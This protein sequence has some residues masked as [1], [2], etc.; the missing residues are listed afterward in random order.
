[1]P[2][3]VLLGTTR[4]KKDGGLFSFKA[5]TCLAEVGPL[6]T[7]IKNPDMCVAGFSALERTG[8]V[9]VTVSNT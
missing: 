8:L 7:E 5:L 2:P 3:R 4:I 9:A 1:M 6:L